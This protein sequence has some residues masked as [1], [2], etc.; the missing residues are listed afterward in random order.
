[1]PSNLDYLVTYYPGAVI[2]ITKDF[3]KEASKEEKKVDFDFENLIKD[4]EKV[5]KGV[6]VHKYPVNTGKT[7]TSSLS[8]QFKGKDNFKNIPDAYNAKSCTC[9]DEIVEII[10]IFVHSK[11]KIFFSTN[12]FKKNKKRLNLLIYF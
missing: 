5:I 2:I 6:S 8:M 9:I 7:W 10:F 1:M 3:T 11:K 4:Y 12:S